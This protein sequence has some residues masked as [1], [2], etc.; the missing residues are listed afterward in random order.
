[1]NII[2][3]EFCFQALLVVLCGGGTGSCGGLLSLTLLTVANFFFELRD[4]VQIARIDA[5]VNDLPWEYTVSKYPTLIFFPA[6]KLVLLFFFF[7]SRI[8]N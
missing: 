6:G 1:M 3:N 4:S 8:I 7:T 2:F 5:S